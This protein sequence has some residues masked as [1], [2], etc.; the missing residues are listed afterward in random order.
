MKST[1]MSTP[2]G[3][4]LKTPRSSFLSSALLVAAAFSVVTAVACADG[5]TGEPE[6]ETG[7]E[8]EAEPE[9]LPDRPVLGTLTIRILDDTTGA[10]VCTVTHTSTEEA[11]DHNFSAGYTYFGDP[12]GEWLS[13]LSGTINSDGVTGPVG[14]ATLVVKK[15]S[16]GVYDLPPS[17][18]YTFALAD[19][20][21]FEGGVSCGTATDGELE[22]YY[23]LAFSSG[24]A[25]TDFSAF[26]SAVSD[27][28]AAGETVDGQWSAAL[29]LCNP[30]IH[31][32]ENCE[33]YDAD[34]A[35]A[36]DA[37]GTGVNSQDGV[38]YQFEVS[39]AADSVP[40][41]ASRAAP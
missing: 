21:E 18:S 33:F 25:T 24:E 32:V 22:T 29:P 2:R 10:E 16:D 27:A 7:G 36:L 31:T 20:L 4:M 40:M 41:A 19:V 13:L 37:T 34:A 11:Y 14:N 30:D 12:D 8:P 1:A 17:T 35:L 23:S 28:D 3:P 39:F 9:P 38:V 6:P 15:A 26:S 5:G